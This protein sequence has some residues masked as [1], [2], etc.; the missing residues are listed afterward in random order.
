[1]MTGGMAM[2]L[3]VFAPMNRADLQ[4]YVEFL[5][6]QYRVMDAFWF[7]YVS[8]AFD[9]QTAETINQRVWG[10]VPDLAA[11]EIIQRFGITEKGLKG[12]AKALNYFP[13]TILI[14]YD[15]EERDD[16]LFIT[17]PSCPPQVARRK[18]GLPEFNCKDMHHGE[19]SSFARVIDERI[20]VD[21]LFAP[22]DPHPDGC[23]CKWRFTLGER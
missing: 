10:R 9:Q 22:P 1:M 23:F 5:L 21:C 12:F 3:S 6:H 7:L 20:T 13:W 18:H 15:V 11:K 19:F 16:E 4:N 2:D 14:G 17:V 8:E